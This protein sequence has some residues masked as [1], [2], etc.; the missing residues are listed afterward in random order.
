MPLL[1]LTV[2]LLPIEKLLKSMMPRWLVCVIVS[3]SLACRSSPCLR[4]NARPVG[5]CSP[6]PPQESLHAPARREEAP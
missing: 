6:A 2:P 1:I 4:Q 3:V 5:A